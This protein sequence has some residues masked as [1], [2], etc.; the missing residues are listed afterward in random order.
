MGLDQNRIKKFVTEN[1]FIVSNHARMRMFQRNI[2]TEDIRHVIF[3]GE[4][5]EDY[6]DDEPC[7]SA[8]LLGFVYEKPCHVVV[9]QC[10]D[11]MRVVTVYIPEK[12]KWIG[13][14][15]RSDKL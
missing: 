3:N 13:F 8:L 10:D 14:R 5:I 1:E 7:P 9:A 11:H 15:I 12:D 6:P 2:S 4:I